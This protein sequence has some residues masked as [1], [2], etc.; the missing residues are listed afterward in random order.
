MLVRVWGGY[1]RRDSALA[2]RM[3][4]SPISTARST[5]PHAE[6][7]PGPGVLGDRGRLGRGVLGCA[8]GAFWDLPTAGSTGAMTIGCFRCALASQ[9]VGARVPRPGRVIIR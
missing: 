5:G 4:R 9:R 2:N 7:S 1:S 3:I 6:M 8:L